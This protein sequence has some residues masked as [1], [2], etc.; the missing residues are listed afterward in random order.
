[1]RDGRSHY[2][3]LGVEAHASA[4]EVK[5]AYKQLAR[6]THPDVSQRSDSAKDFVRVLEAWEVLGDQQQRSRYD[7]EHGLGASAGPK[8][9]ANAAADTS[10]WGAHMG[11]SPEAGGLNRSSN[12][13]IRENQHFYR[14]KLNQTPKNQA[15]RDLRKQARKVKVT[16]PVSM[17]AKAAIPLVGV[18]A[19]AYFAFAASF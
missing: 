18:A 14:S 6:D 1:M 15:E 7:R 12:Y 5:K 3:V 8:G 17:G 19:W 4:E 13:M 11:S 16:S 2:D 9:A 10:S